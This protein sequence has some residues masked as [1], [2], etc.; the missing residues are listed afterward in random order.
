MIHRAFAIA[1]I[2]SAVFLGITVF[3]AV[4]SNCDIDTQQHRVSI[5]GNCHATVAHGRI[6]F[7]NNAKFGPY[8]GGAVALSDDV[9]VV[10]P[11]TETTGFGD[12][13]GIY[14]RH[15]RW[16]DSDDIVWTAAISPAYPVLVFA[17]LP[18]I[19]AGCRWRRRRRLARELSREAQG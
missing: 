14:Y 19:W 12:A 15:V 4:A 17:L 5:T 7:F 11:H 9:G 13:W 1:T 2:L 3:L 16:L 10:R 6:V 18:A 8:L